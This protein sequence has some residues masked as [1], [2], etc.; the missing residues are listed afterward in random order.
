[1]TATQSGEVE[2]YSRQRK[3]TWKLP[4]AKKDYCFFREL[5]RFYFTKAG[6][7]ISFF[8]NTWILRGGIEIELVLKTRSEG[9]NIFN[10]RHWS[11]SWCHGGVF[12]EFFSKRH[13]IIKFIFQ[14][15]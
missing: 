9:Y 3:N 4:R 6:A 13:N 2:R 11:W 1:M 12:E 10:A 7:L 5:G 8:F 14:D 15:D